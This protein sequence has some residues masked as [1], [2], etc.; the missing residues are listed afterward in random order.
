VLSAVALTI[1]G[2]TA[3]Q[4]QVPTNL[5]LAA[6]E[7][8]PAFA[9]PNAP[10]SAVS[11]ADSAWFDGDR[12]AALRGY[13]EAFAGDDPA[14]QAM[15][16]L[17][18][19][20]LTTNLS[21]AF[22][23]PRIDRALT[24]CDD[25]A[26]C[27][28]AHADYHLFAPAEV[29]AQRVRAIDYA[30]RAKATLPGPAAARL[31]MA[32]ADPIYLT[33]LAAEA[34]DG[35]GQGFADHNGQLPQGPGATFVGVGL[36]G[37]PGLGYGGSL[38]YVQPDLFRKGAQLRITAAGTHDGYGSAAA[39]LRSPG[40]AYIAGGGSASRVPLNRYDDDS[41]TALE[42]LE[43]D[44]ALAWIGVG[45]RFKPHWTVVRL[46]ERVDAV[47]TTPIQGVA[48]DIS[49]GWEARG[50]WGA[51]RAGFAAWGHVERALEW[52]GADYPLTKA[53][54]TVV[55]YKPVAGWVIA[56]RAVGEVV[57]SSAP[58]FRL[59]SAGGADLLRGAPYGRYRGAKLAAVD[60]EL[61]KMLIGPVEG[62]VFGSAAAVSDWG[63]HPT[64]GLGV[65]LLLPPNRTDGL[66]IDLGFSEEGWALAT[67]WSEAF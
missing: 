56:G 30:E 55:A 24:A 15:A 36:M 51:S 7:Q 64:A 60:L 48:L 46:E 21:M 40:I 22:I 49:G 28:L 1:A 59:P 8:A 33:F 41:P 61:R 67:G 45:A 38:R 26:W 39:D 6:V 9:F 2:L 25:S 12:R 5:P 42:T 57:N 43:V 53:K 65:R 23:G 35:L 50:G 10:L 34:S 62:V 27:L 44:T 29:G 58:F 47:G 52:L 54:G 37:A 18:L 63:L 31:W 66:R 11:A 14:A 4:A 32:T 17:R 16:G 20:H 13:R 3:T 19:L